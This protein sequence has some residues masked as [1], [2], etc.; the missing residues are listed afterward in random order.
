MADELSLLNF[1]QDYEEVLT[2]DDA[3]RWKL[4]MPGDLEVH[5][6]MSSVKA[7]QEVFQARLLWITYPQE[8]PSLKFRDI[9]KSRLDLPSAWPELV[10]SRA[11]RPGS[12]DTCVNWTVEGFNLHPEW[13]NDPNNKWVST[14]NVLLKC[15]RLLQRELDEY[16]IKRFG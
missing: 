7:P 6:C 12:L 2:C 8:P 11:F 9:D 3:R 1:K 16:F 13:K 4:E 10:G 5:A 14:G 15:L